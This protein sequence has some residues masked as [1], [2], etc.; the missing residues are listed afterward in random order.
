MGKQTLILAPVVEQD[1][2]SILDGLVFGEDTQQWMDWIEAFHTW[3]ESKRRRS[4]AGNTVSTYRTAWK[5]FYRWA[6][7]K[8][9]EVTL[10]LAQQWTA[11]LANVEGLAESSVN[12][13]LAAMSSFYDFVQRQ[14][15]LWPADRRNPFKAVERNRVSAYGRAKYPSVEEA[16][17]M[18]S[19]I[20]TDSLTGKRDLALLFLF[21]TTCRRS[22]EILNLRWGEVQ[23]GA[24]GD[25]VFSYR[26]KGGEQK[27]AVI[28]R[29]AW[30]LVEVY[31]GAAG[32]LPMEDGDYIFTA[33]DPDRASRLGHSPEVNA[34]ITNSMANKLLKKY[35]RR[36][37][38]DTKKAHIHG[39]RHVGARLRVKLM[40]E[41]KGSVDFEEVMHL[42]GH[43][44]LAVT[45]IY[46]ATV[47]DDPKDKG[48]AGAVEALLPTQRR[49]RG[50]RPEAEQIGLEGASIESALAEIRRLRTEV[51]QLK[52]RS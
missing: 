39:L 41:G 19:T 51:E 15:D 20:N 32:R 40:R 27:R 7:V 16:R 4:G 13:K 47:L 48:A 42:L 38:V 1:T 45:Q 8:P 30:Q 23:E 34:P 24:D 14:Y 28:E 18:L 33:L 21:L 10:R 50:A 35:A 11:V 26:Y 29:R 3:L 43:S 25:Y 6:Q 37:G 9:W 52:A 17:S 46:A 36:A 31:L 22:S 49:R 5:Q 44:S 12:L 2:V